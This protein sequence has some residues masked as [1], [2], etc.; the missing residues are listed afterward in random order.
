MSK[1][2]FVTNKII[3]RCNLKDY[4][5]HYLELLCQAMRHV[6]Y[7]NVCFTDPAIG[8]D[9]QQTENPIVCKIMGYYQGMLINGDG[10]NPMGLDVDFDVVKYL[11]KK[12][13]R[14][15]DIVLH[16]EMGD[17]TKENQMLVCE[18]K[19]FYEHYQKERKRRIDPDK[20]LEDLNKLI[21]LT[22]DWIWKDDGEEIG[23]GFGMGAFICLNGTQND[24][25]NNLKIYFNDNT[26]YLLNS[27]QEGIADYNLTFK[28]FCQNFHKEIGKLFVICLSFD[29]SKHPHVELC[30]LED[31]IKVVMG[32]SI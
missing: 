7:D 32:T 9:R 27:L 30:L 17:L 13:Y 29:E 8:T 6:T 24:L 12:L 18:V 26:E 23:K 14:K 19:R 28:G 2:E 10:N 31:V 5:P 21:V 15:P 4:Q 16:K 22:S 20:I 25:I 1:K 11:R 3:E